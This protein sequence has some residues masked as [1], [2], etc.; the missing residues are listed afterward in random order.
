M[1]F[2]YNNRVY[3]NR[4][5]AGIARHLNRALTHV[6]ADPDVPVKE[7][8]I[9]PAGEKNR[10]LIEFNRTAADYPK[11]K[12]LHRLFEEQVA[13]TPDRSAVNRSYKTYRT[14]IEGVSPETAANTLICLVHQT[15]FLLDQ[16]LRQLEQ[17]FLAQ[18]GFTE[19]LYHARKH[20]RRKFYPN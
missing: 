7:I 9:L 20:A 8:E 10:I 5:I 3:H 17:L 12:T 6:L 15:N 11:D 14:Y 1:V 4:F 18:R 13:R 19:K 2:G 16:Q